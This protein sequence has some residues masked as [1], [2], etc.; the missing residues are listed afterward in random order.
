MKE[1]KHKNYNLQITGIASLP[2]YVLIILI[3][4]IQIGLTLRHLRVLKSGLLNI[5]W[6]VT[7]NM[8]PNCGKATL[9]SLNCVAYLNSL[10]SVS[11]TVLQTQ[12]D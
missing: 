5:V 9:S 3:F 12:S 2:N 7:I 6:N 8:V 11:E 1:C 4:R 10:R